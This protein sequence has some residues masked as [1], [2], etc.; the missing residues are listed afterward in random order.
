M[1][2]PFPSLAK[3]WM[4]MDPS[5]QGFLA[6][7]PRGSG[8]S[9][10]KTPPPGAFG[11]SGQLAVLGVRDRVLLLAVGHGSCVPIYGRLLS[12]SWIWW[13]GYSDAYTTTRWEA[14]AGY[15]LNRA[16]RLSACT[17]TYAEMGRGSRSSFFRASHVNISRSKLARGRLHLR[18]QTG[19]SDRRRTH[20]TR[21]L[22]G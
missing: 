16:A 22:A 17:Y 1:T 6:G 7:A 15:V 5:D 2:L 19:A 10:R 3:R 9:F 11:I 8:V 13:I 18:S 20:S 4:D 12:R 14:V 21:A